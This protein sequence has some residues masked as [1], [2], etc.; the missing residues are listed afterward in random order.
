MAQAAPVKKGQVIVLVLVALFFIGKCSGSSDDSDSNYTPQFTP[1][2]QSPS[3][4][5]ADRE[6]ADVGRAGFE[7]FV[8]QDEA[9]AACA[10]LNAGR[11]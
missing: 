1:S 10:V 4:S 2:V 9:L 7:E 3:F 6:C 8:S 11:P 5:S